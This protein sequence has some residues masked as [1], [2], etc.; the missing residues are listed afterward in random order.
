MSILWALVAVVF[1]GPA[2]FA[3]GDRICQDL[4]R[5]ACAPGPVD[6]G[7]G[8]AASQDTAD[9]DLSAVKKQI[10]ERT[11]NAFRNKLSNPSNVYFRRLV[12]SATALSSRDECDGADT[13][14]TDECM[15]LMVRS[16]TNIEMKKIETSANQI[17]WSSGAG[18]SQQLSDIDLLMNNADFQDVES[19]VAK[20]AA[21]VIN[22][23]H[24]DE[25]IEK[26]S[27]SSN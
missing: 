2:S 21:A 19:K 25:E 8:V 16:C 27:S 1:I 17:V 3:G 15:D 22:P 6:D 9:S 4:Y 7:T 14:P 23:N 13:M 24:A 10:A 20:N 26:K 18:I 12:L 5:S 11:A